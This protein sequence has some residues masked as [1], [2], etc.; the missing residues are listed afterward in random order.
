MSKTAQIHPSATIDPSTHVG[1]GTKIWRNVHVMDNV[2]IGTDCTVGEGVHIGPDCSIGHG[3]KIQN[4]AQLFSA[5]NLDEKVFVG[6]HVVFCNVKTPRA[7]IPRMHE[8]GTTTVE[9]G[10]SI[11]A[12]ATILPGIT[13]GAYAMIGAGATVTKDVPEYTI[14]VGNPAK[15]LGYVCICG[16]GALL[17]PWK[18]GTNNW[19]PSCEDC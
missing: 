9:A 5:V 6:P 2:M 19:P 1:G 3:C 15:P 4:G 16:K 8:A 10:A 11:G 14:V 7:F 18:P 13:I 17:G 12:N